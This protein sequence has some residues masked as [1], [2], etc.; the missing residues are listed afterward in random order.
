M[1]KIRIINSKTNSDHKFGRS[2]K[3]QIRLQIQ[4]RS[5]IGDQKRLLQRRRHHADEL[6][7]AS[8]ENSEG[9][10]IWWTTKSYGTS[11]LAQF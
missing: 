9:N 7:E 6:K 2:F 5:Q 8:A 11:K 1:S 3:L 10:S 4:F